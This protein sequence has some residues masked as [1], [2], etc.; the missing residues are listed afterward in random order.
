VI[1]TTP[2]ELCHAATALVGASPDAAFAFAAEPARVGEW[3]LG[4]FAARPVGD[5]VFHGRAL[6][7]DSITAFRAEVDSVRRTVDYH[8][9][10]PGGSLVMRISLRVLD[11][12]AFGYGPAQCLLSMFAWRPADFD[13]QRWRRTIALHE[14]EIVLL[15]G[16]IEKAARADR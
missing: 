12:A 16:R 1:E 10:A 4:S 7:D 3:T 6:A 13:A 2:H 15:K 9:G 8:V 5:G 14:A 11:G